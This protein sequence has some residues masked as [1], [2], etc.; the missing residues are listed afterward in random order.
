MLLLLKGGR[1]VK[2]QPITTSTKKLQWNK[3]T[4]FLILG[5]VAIAMTLRMPLTM[6]GPIIGFIRENLGISNVVAGFLTTIP[7]L[8]F[9]IVSPLTP[10]IAKRFSLELTLWMATLLLITGITIRSFSST[11]TLIIGT[12]LIG[13]AISFGNVLI[14]S[15]F[16]LKFPFQIGLL[17]GIYTVAM[18][19]SAGLGAGLS[20]PI[21]LHK[22]FGWQGALGVSVIIAI[23]AFVIWLPQLRV[24]KQ[25]LTQHVA[26]T[27]HIE[28]P[29]WRS[30]LAWAVTFAMGLQSFIF[31]TTSAWIPEIVIS[32][33]MDAER[34]GWMVSII[35]LSQ[36]PMTFF[37][38]IAASKMASQH[39]LVALFTLFYIIGFTGLYMEWT[40]LAVV[41]MIFLGFGGGSSF[42]LAMMFFTLRTKTA[43]EAAVLSGFAQSIGYSLAA[44]GPILF[45]YLYD[46]TNNWDIPIIVFFIITA[47][48]FFSGMRAGKNEYIH[49][50]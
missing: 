19:A 22:S 38:P 45:G 1:N 33:G 13:I 31:Y 30:P 12:I 40:E 14:P 4:V 35:Q 18:N 47:L 29:L 44:T 41:W 17:T 28:Q 2:Q 34:A 10:K 16:K 50:R 11:T 27:Q 46:F 26:T 37:M 49:S 36:I 3:H 9:A 23:I 24:K 48:L 5:I 39:P 20:Y 15:F 25:P 7:L 8:A 6:V 43:Y 32:Q 21:A 42:A